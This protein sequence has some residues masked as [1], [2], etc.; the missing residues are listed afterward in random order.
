[1]SQPAGI[2]DPPKKERVENLEK[3]ATHL[4]K[5]TVRPVTMKSVRPPT[6]ERVRKIYSPYSKDGN[7]Y[8]EVTSTP[9]GCYIKSNNKLVGMFIPDVSNLPLCYSF[10]RT[11][12][13]GIHY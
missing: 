10:D 2:S 4:T 5:E 7:K 6:K 1:L 3:L 8:V 9:T 11:I 13:L 12:I